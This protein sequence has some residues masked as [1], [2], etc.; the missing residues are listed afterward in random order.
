MSLFATKCP[1]C[2]TYLNGKDYYEE[3]CL[4]ESYWECPH[5]H[6]WF[7][8]SYGATGIFIGRKRFTISYSDSCEKQEEFKNNCAKAVFQYQQ[9]HKLKL[10]ELLI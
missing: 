4:S 9:R 7:E 1:V 10:V 8:F 2:G 6:Y 5:K 3:S